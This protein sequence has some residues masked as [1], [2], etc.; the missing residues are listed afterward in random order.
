MGEGNDTTDISGLTSNHHVVV[1]TGGG[2]DQFVGQRSIDELIVG[3]SAGGGSPAGSG[4]TGG[5]G[6]TGNGSGNGGDDVAG[7]G[8]LPLSASDVTA[9]KNLVNGLQ[10]AAKT[11]TPT[12][13]RELSGHGNNLANPEYGRGRSALHPHH[14]RALRRARSGDRQ[15]R[16]Q[17][18]LRRARSA[19]DQQRARHAG[20]RPAAGRQRCQHLLHGVRPVLRPR[21]RLPRQGR[22]RHDR[23]RRRRCRARAGHP[24]TRPT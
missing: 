16:H 7:N 17:P 21:P 2:S 11:M 22:Q 6:G 13:V 4:G 3:P 9:L 18:D 19:R 1:T 20:G 14:Q 5:T 8:A 12:G 10:P 15:L 23:D 24:T